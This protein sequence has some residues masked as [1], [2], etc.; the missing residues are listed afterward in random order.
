MIKNVS[1]I[2]NTKGAFSIMEKN[3]MCFILA[4]LMLFSSSLYGDIFTAY[5][6]IENEPNGWNAGALFRLF[7]KKKDNYTLERYS[8][9][10]KI[11]DRVSPEPITVTILLGFYN[12]KKATAIRIEN[13]VNA[14]FTIRENIWPLLEWLQESFAGISEQFDGLSHLKPINTN[15]EFKHYITIK[16]P[17]IS[18]SLIDMLSL[19]DQQEDQLVHHRNEGVIIDS[20]TDPDSVSITLRI[21]KKNQVTSIKVDTHVAGWY[22]INTNIE[23]L[24]Q[25]LQ[26][27]YPELEKLKVAKVQKFLDY[28]WSFF[29]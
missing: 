16:N 23:P 13:H 21:N 25:Y 3:H 24:L 9:A 10:I 15:P 7:D 22:E 19:F 8:D 17:E 5:E 27:S 29:H 4:L 12:K 28:C 18:L 14:R 26:R 11:V 2:L 20:L 1:L 6:H